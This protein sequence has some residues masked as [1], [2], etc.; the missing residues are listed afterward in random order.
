MGPVK[1][2]LKNQ[3]KKVD[4]NYFIGIFSKLILIK[5]TR[6]VIRFSALPLSLLIGKFREDEEK[7]NNKNVRRSVKHGELQIRLVK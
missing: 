6:Y 1:R 7:K 2:Y 3:N 5:F 4:L